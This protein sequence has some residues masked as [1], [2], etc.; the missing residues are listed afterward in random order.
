L[1]SGL[2]YD[3][4]RIHEQGFN[5]GAESALEWALGREDALSEPV[6]TVAVSGPAEHDDAL[7]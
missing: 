7:P 4:N 1:L 2:F 3:H 6:L 5:C